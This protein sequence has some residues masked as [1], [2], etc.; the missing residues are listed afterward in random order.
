MSKK[1]KLDP[2]DFPESDQ[3]A[4]GD[5]VATEPEPAPAETRP[6]ETKAEKFKRLANR[7]VP[8]AVKALLNI[9][10]LANRQNY[11]Y[12]DAERDIVLSHI[13]KAYKALCDAFKQDQVSPPNGTLF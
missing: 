8:N 9:R 11:A 6:T 12:S 5:P 1:R 7:R 3:A 13:E 10:R 2:S 4:V